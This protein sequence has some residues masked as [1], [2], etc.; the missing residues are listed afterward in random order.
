M[1]TQQRR[2]T[3]ARWR[4]STHSILIPQISLTSTTQHA[5]LTCAQ[6]TG[7]AASYKARLWV[8]NSLVSLVGVIINS[9]SIFYAVFAPGVRPGCR[10][11]T[12]TWWH[13]TI[14]HSQVWVIDNYRRRMT[15]GVRLAHILTPV[16]PETQL[17]KITNSRSQ[18]ISTGCDAVRMN[19]TRGKRG[20]QTPLEMT[21]LHI[22]KELNVK[23]SGSLG[24]RYNWKESTFSIT[25]Q[26]SKP[27][28]NKNAFKGIPLSDP[29]E[30]GL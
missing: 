7:K 2:H 3:R 24:M 14:N 1:T 15:S 10:Q 16:L 29:Q 8:I 9:T 25:P 17:T 12:R 28:R 6:K 27:R 18:I 19:T 11:A 13:Y 21:R 22:P 4:N 30:R 5:S 23:N 26:Y 20:R